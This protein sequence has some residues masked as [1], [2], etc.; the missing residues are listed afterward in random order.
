MVGPEGGQAQPRAIDEFDDPIG[1]IAFP[2]MT[3][4]AER[5]SD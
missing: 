1:L 3:D 4:D 2:A 5:L